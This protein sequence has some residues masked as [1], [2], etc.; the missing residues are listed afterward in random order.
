MLE[1]LAIATTLNH[2]ANPSSSHGGT[3][4]R[5]RL[6]KLLL[7]KALALI[8]TGFLEG[9]LALQAGEI[10]VH[11]TV[12]VVPGQHDGALTAG[13]NLA[14][15]EG[16]GVGGITGEKSFATGTE[17]ALIFLR[18]FAGSIRAG[19]LWRNR[20]I[21]AV[22]LGCGGSIRAV[23]FGRG[24]SITGCGTV[25][26]V[27]RLGA[28]FG[29]FG[30]LLGL[31]LS[32]TV[33]TLGSGGLRLVAS[34]SVLTNGFLVGFLGV[35]VLCLFFGRVGRGDVGAVVGV[36]LLMGGFLRSQCLRRDGRAPGR[37]RAV[38]SIE[39]VVV[40][41]KGFEIGDTRVRARRRVVLG[42]FLE[43]SSGR[44]LRVGVQN[45]GDVGWLEATTA[46]LEGNEGRH[47]DGPCAACDTDGYFFLWRIW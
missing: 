47:S 12:V 10:S 1:F 14:S 16:A 35:A 46:M 22:D 11:T 30:L 24:R 23:D 20:S 28:A 15:G 40:G 7:L 32:I 41:L 43:D 25:G 45:F 9:D 5:A 27:F 3:L 4:L 13:E 39:C 19:G 21:R 33:V 38:L 37:S 34:T 42:T 8:L 29:M 31:L 6:C 36:A 26:I 2:A 18:S 44:L 17:R